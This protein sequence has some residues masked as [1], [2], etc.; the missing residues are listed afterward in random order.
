VDELQQ[1][2]RRFQL[3]VAQVAE[4]ESGSLT[5][6]VGPP[7][8]HVAVE[9]EDHAAA[10]LA[11]QALD[12]TADHRPHPR[13]KIRHGEL[14]H[15]A[16]LAASFVDERGRQRLGLHRSTCHTTRC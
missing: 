13:G 16:N 5:G 11:V 1:V 9:R 3:L 2:Q 12:Q 8:V 14:G 6:K 15:A 4:S 10:L 7:L